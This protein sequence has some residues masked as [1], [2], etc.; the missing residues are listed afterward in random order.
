MASST[1]TSR[2][3]RRFGRAALA[4]LAVAGV[5]AVAGPAGAAEGSAPTVPTEESTVPVGPAAAPRASEGTTT[6]LTASAT[7]VVVGAPVTVT[8]TVTPAT[9]AVVE[10]GTVDF[11]VGSTSLGPAVVGP[12]GEATRNVTFAS[13]GAHALTA[14]FAG[15]AEADPSTSTALTI[16]ATAPVTPPPTGS[17]EPAST[18]RG[19]GTGTGPAGQTLTVTPNEGLDPGGTDVTL[20]GTGYTAAAGFDI[21]AEGMYVALCVDKGPGAVP[22]PC[23]GG[24]DMSGTAGSS[25]WVTNNPY[26]GVPPGAVAAVAPDGSFTVELTLVASDEFV[27]CLD[28][29]AGERCVLAS[30][31]DHRASADR[32]QDVKVAL[33]WEGQAACTTDPIPPADPDDPGDAAPFSGYRLTPQTGTR[34]AGGGLAA[35]GAELR[36]LPWGL[37]L[38]GAGLALV[39]VA[40]RLIRT[41]PSVPSPGGPLP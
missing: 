28:L 20:T 34:A 2:P 29:P 18:A 17:T 26:D 31:M 24:A 6:V 23:V 21:A 12:T 32:S 10:G 3:A 7:T 16:T 14:S 13:A 25:K 19:T 36:P 9:T 38:L 4:A 5:V 40:R 39:L 27:D 35:T 33:C 37:A 22:S 15:T 30:R 11:L 41:S 1:P 8:A